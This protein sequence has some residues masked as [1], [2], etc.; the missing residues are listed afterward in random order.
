[1]KQA[2]LLLCCGAALALFLLHVRNDRYEEISRRAEHEAAPGERKLKGSLAQDTW[3]L[4]SREIAEIDAHEK[5]NTNVNISIPCFGLGVL[6]ETETD[7]TYSLV[8]PCGDVPIG[9]GGLEVRVA[10]FT[11]RIPEPKRLHRWAAQVD[12]TW[13]G[14]VHML[15]WLF[16]TYDIM[17]HLFFLLF[18]SLQPDFFDGYID[19]FNG[20]LDSA[21]T[22]LAKSEVE[23]WNATRYE[24][25]SP[26]FV[27]PGNIFRALALF[28]SSDPN[29][30]HYRYWYYAIKAIMCAFMML[31]IPY[32]I[33][34]ESL[35]NWHFAGPKSAMWLFQNGGTFAATFLATAQLAAVFWSRTGSHFQ[36]GAVA[37][38]YILSHKPP[39]QGTGTF[40]NQYEKLA[41]A[42]DSRDLPQSSE[43][44]WALPPWYYR[45]QM[46]F[47]CNLSMCLNAW[48]CIML[49]LA[50]LLKA[51]TFKGSTADLAINITAL[52]F[53]FE[54]DR[55]VF[56]SDPS[57]QLRYRYMI[58]RQATAGLRHPDERI[59]PQRMR[60]AVGLTKIAFDFSF[61]YVLLAALSAAW[62]NKDSDYIG[63]D[64]L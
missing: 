31:Y 60:K 38:S 25:D 24:F 37:N 17:L 40:E 54:L 62:R 42:P 22:F 46:W 49:P 58:K 30:G 4:T 41:Q 29:V 33:V 13:G 18:R 53:V 1:M 64:K 47:W 63:L 3:V 9:P 50:F 39:H 56:E 61:K 51:S 59:W 27:A 26:I 15:L 48:M 44:A 45:L 8:E 5:Q 57:L 21:D 10:W 2:P 14:W 52:Y 20:D 34:M 36:N 7:Y 12:S 55:Q 16:L 35:A 28:Q 23:Q 19:L 11:F 43:P 32:S 6:E